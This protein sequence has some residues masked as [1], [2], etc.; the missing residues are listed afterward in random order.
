M[1]TIANVFGGMTIRFE[2]SFS[3]I[4]FIGRKPFW[5]TIQIEYKPD[6]RLL[7]FVS[8]EEWLGIL[9]DQHVVIEEVARLTFDEVTRVLGD[10]PLRI[11]VSARTTVH[12]PASAQIS[13][14]W[15]H[16]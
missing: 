10:I 1:D 13:R 8:I 4:C 5:G 16:E 2:P 3:A 9:G 14:R 7:E 11:T 6:D 12:A 15:E